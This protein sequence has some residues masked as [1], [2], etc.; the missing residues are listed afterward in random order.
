[1]S[2]WVRSKDSSRVSRQGIGSFMTRVYDAVRGIVLHSERFNLPRERSST[3]PRLDL[4]VV[5]FGMVSGLG[6]YD[7]KWTYR[8]AMGSVCYCNG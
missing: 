5:F 7:N 3:F 8:L 4:A 2:D 1:M 6:R